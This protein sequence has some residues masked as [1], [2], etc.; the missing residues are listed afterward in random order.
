MLTNHSLLPKFDFGDSGPNFFERPL[1]F[2][3]ENS[4]YDSY[5]T[6]T[7]EP[8]LYEEPAQPVRSS[9]DARAAHTAERRTSPPSFSIIKTPPV[10]QAPPQVVSPPSPTISPPPTSLPLQHPSPQR[11]ISPPQGQAQPHLNIPP[12]PTGQRSPSPSGSTSPP[13]SSGHGHTPSSYSTPPSSVTHLQVPP[14]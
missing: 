2:S 12:P 4:I 13:S 1:S 6:I 3:E 8:S 7:E 10:A 9:L 5:A 14:G 11:P